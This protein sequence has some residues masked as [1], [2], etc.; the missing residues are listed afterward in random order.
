MLPIVDKPLLE[1]LVEDL[2][3]N[4][5]LD[6][7]IVSHKTKVEIQ[8]Y[9][10]NDGISFSYIYPNEPKGVVDALLHAEKFVGE[11]PFVLLFGDAVFYS[12]QN[13]IKQMISLFNKT[14]K[15]IA[16]TIEVKKEDR[17]QYGIVESKKVG[18]YS[19][20]YNIIE[21]PKQNETDSL[22]A[23]A[24][25][26]VLLPEIFLEL[27]QIEIGKLFTDALCHISF[28]KR[29][30]SK[31]IEGEY[32]D[33]GSK[34]GF[35][36]ANIFYALRNKNLKKDVKVYINKLAKKGEKQPK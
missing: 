20:I 17:E 4:G 10:Q 34:L 23:L 22:L 32:F 14:Q 36:K 12:K 26:Y 1:Y 13:S 16:A 8:N 19:Y 5:I 6:V 24:G 30:L 9:F 11:K 33:V 25:Q 27:K 31:K 21:K 2:K 15:N 18:P 28:C 35:I 29:L 7:L 3:L